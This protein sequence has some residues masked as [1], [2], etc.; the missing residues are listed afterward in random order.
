MADIHKMVRTLLKSGTDVG[1]IC[2]ID[3]SAKWY[4]KNVR[5]T[6]A[7]RGIV[8]VAKLLQDNE[9]VTVLF[10][11]GT[12]FCVMKSQSPCYALTFKSVPLVVE[13]NIRS[14]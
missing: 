5:E 11:K 6:P 1:K 10:D 12:G 9:I 13:V 4:A 7:N 8:K 2:Q 14:N 3:V